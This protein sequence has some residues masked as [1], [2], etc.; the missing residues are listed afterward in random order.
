MIK[1]DNETYELLY[2][3]WVQGYISG[4]NKQLDSLGYKKVDLGSVTQLGDVL[5]V[6]CDNAVKQGYGTMPVSI[7]VDKVF[8]EA[9]D[10]KV[11]K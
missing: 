10:K 4:R 8:E 6:T 5:V 1:T 2:S 9:F 3:T 11:R 7:V